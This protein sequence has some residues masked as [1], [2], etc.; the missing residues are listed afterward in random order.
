MQHADK[1]TLEA[2]L[3][4][5]S[6]SPDDRRSALL[7]LRWM[8]DSSPARSQRFGAAPNHAPRTAS[9]NLKLVERPSMWDDDEALGDGLKPAE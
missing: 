2:Q 4:F 6:L 3:L 7:M 8:A 9:N 1:E 5:A